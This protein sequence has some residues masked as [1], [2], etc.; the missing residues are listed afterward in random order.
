[1][2]CC[3]VLTACCCWLAV[4]PALS[5]ADIRYTVTD[6][7]AAIGPSASDVTVSALNDSGHVAGTVFTPA[8][9]SSQAF[10]YDGVRHDLGT[11]GSDLSHG[12]GINNSDQVVGYASVP[13]DPSSHAF[14][15]DGTMHDLGI[16]G[17]AYAINNQGQVTGYAGHPFLY[18]GTMH[19]LGTLG[20]SFGF[21]YAINDHG[22]IT[23]TAALPGSQVR[24]A[25]Q[26]DGT[27][28]DLGTLGGQ[29]S[30]GNSINVT[31]LITGGATLPAQIDPGGIERT[32]AF[33]YDGSMHDLG[34]IDGLN[35]SVGTGIN[36]H[37]QL[38]GYSYFDPS[39]L[40]IAQSSADDRAFLYTV[41][42]GMVDL[43][44]LIDP[45]SAWL[46]N[47]A[48]AIN[49]AGQILGAGTIGGQWHAFLL[50]PVPEPSAAI[51]LLVAGAVA[52][53]AYRRRN[54]S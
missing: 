12:L 38:V 6:L 46:L 45:N 51:Q 20:G 10:F 37:V 54:A 1:M 8:D 14:L 25:F 49:N 31:G 23:G 44:S 24:H 11:L 48:T 41:Q 43:N 3:L 9:L 18:D 17:M 40:S 36:D 29:N 35:S 50:T 28:H 42:N 19:D 7:G 15:Y 16:H 4:N 2:K 53:F 21:G 26:Y 39:P 33:L 52:M 27:M 30:V 32:H 34:T 13:G 47:D 22:Q 5:Q